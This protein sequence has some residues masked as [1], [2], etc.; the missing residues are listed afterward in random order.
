VDLLVFV[1]NVN[2]LTSEFEDDDEHDA[3]PP[4]L[5]APA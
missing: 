1:A 4:S 2:G 3:W 5:Q